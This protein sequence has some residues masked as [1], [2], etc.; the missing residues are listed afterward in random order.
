MAGF[1]F[2]FRA[3]KSGFFDAPKARARVQTAEAKLQSRFGAIVRRRMKT[4]IRYR[5]TGSAPAG[6]P[7]VAHRS[8][9]FTRTR[10]CTPSRTG[11]PKRQAQSPLRELI[12]F[13]RDPAT[14]TVVIGPVA[15]GAHGAAALEKGGTVTSRRG[16]ARKTVVLAPHP[17]ARPAGDQVARALPDLLRALVN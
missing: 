3:L 11:A 8:S 6:S 10:T 14:H 12:F 7:P 4:S 16:A 9:G 17:F 5:A 15:F 1:D 2:K 13:A